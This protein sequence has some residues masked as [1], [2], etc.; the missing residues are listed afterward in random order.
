[1]PREICFQQISQARVIV[2]QQDRRV[3]AP[4]IERRTRVLARRNIS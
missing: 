2:D 1:V 3:H 4:I